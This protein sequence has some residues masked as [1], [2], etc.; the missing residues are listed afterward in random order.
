MTPRL[1]AALRGLLEHG[2]GLTTDYDGAS[3]ANEAVVK[4]RGRVTTPHPLHALV[5]DGVHGWEVPTPDGTEEGAEVE[6]SVRCPH[7]EVSDD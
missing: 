3:G 6:I 7:V 5:T 2:R 1:L 4:V